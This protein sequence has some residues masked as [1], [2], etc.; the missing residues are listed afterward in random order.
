MSFDKSLREI[1]R[2][3]SSNDDGVTESTHFKK[4]SIMVL[5][6][7]ADKFFRRP[8]SGKKSPKKQSK[9]KSKG[10]DPKVSSF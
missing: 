10:K 9:A 7:L 2:E 1:L 6:N 5:T 8:S 4:S 3:K